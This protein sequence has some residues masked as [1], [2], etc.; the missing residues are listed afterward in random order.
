MDESAPLFESKGLTLGGEL[1]L[2]VGSMTARGPRVA[3]WDE[4]GALVP[5]FFDSSRLREGSLLLRGRKPADLLASGQ[6]ALV[7]Q[8]LPLPEG[9]KLL[10]ALT[11][12]ARLIGL[13]RADAERALGRCRLTAHGGK[14]LGE[15]T[16]LQ[17]RLS[18]LAHGLIGAPRLLLLENPFA[19]LDDAE[20][21][22]VEAVLDVELADRSFIA[23]CSSRDPASRALALTADEAICPAGNRLLPP[24]PP[25]LESA[26]GYW[27]SCSDNAE[28]LAALLSSE[29]AHVAKSPRPSVLLVRGTKGSTIYRLARE[30]QLNVIELTPWGPTS[31]GAPS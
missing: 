1:P 19:D 23:A 7:P 14:K 8:R 26:S 17:S 11:L 21:A 22:I 30:A 3:L 13:S 15:L 9:V 10:E 18:G 24:A 31:D 4:A 28:R 5:A 27:V 6:A 25:R 2:E 29:G 16:R 12:S 20:S